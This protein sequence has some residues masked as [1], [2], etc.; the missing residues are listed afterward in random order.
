LEEL[1]DLKIF[2]NASAGH[3]KRYGGPHLTGGRYLPTPVL[4][5][6]RLFS[7]LL[8]AGLTAMRHSCLLSGSIHEMFVTKTNLA[9]RRPRRAIKN[10]VWW[11]CWRRCSA[12]F[13]VARTYLSYLAAMWSSS[14]YSRNYSI[15]K[16]I[17]WSNNCHRRKN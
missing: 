7:E 3:W 9:A 12:K 13:L 2:L 4:D 11:I 16:V 17:S 1:S 14:G 15:S 10:L 6:S 5:R 8:S